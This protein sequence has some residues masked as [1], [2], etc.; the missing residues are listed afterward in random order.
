MNKFQGFII[1]FH[2]PLCKTKDER[3]ILMLGLISLQLYAIPLTFTNSPNPNYHILRLPTLCI[4]KHGKEIQ[5][6]SHQLNFTA[7]LCMH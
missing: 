3:L 7:Y 1:F 2:F 4:F 6:K 5:R